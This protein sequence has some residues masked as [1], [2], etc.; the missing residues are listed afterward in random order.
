MCHGER[1]GP[2]PAAPP[3]RPHIYG[4]VSWHF[5][6][7]EGARYLLVTDSGSEIYH[8]LNKAAESY[9]A[10]KS[11]L[12]GSRRVSLTQL[13]PGGSHVDELVWNRRFAEVLPEEAWELWFG[14]VT[15]HHFMRGRGK[16][17]SVS[18]A[19]DEYVEKMAEKIAPGRNDLQS[20][21][22]LLSRYAE[23][24]VQR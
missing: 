14:R 7:T 2:R 23:S 8:D 22:W 9:D 4:P 5:T 13:S 18:D 17:D 10:A 3:L 19:I 1:V 16:W 21:A 11:E 6:H 12:G 24:E 15:P 20:E